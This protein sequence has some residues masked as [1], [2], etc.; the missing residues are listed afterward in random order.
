MRKTLKMIQGEAIVGAW[1][2]QH[3]PG[4]EVVLIN[5]DGEQERTRTRSIAWTLGDGTPVVRVP[6]GT[7]V[8]ILER[9]VPVAEDHDRTETLLKSLRK[10]E[11]Y[12]RSPGF[13]A[14]SSD[15][16]TQGPWLADEIDAAISGTH[17][18]ATR[19]R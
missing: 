15:P 7:E 13:A 11:G 17:D 5:D 1:N 14:G 10:I 16:A 4:R 9:V 19:P 12:L 3:P 6:G 2:D 8:Y 18:G